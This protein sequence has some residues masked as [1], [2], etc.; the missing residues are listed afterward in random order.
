MTGRRQTLGDV[1]RLA[2]VSLTTASVALTG[3]P[4]VAAETRSR[5]ERAAER[6]G[7]VPDSAG[8][9]LRSR[10]TGALAVVV[11]HS[12]RHF[13]SHPVLVDLLEGVMSVANERDL[14][15]IV[16]TSSTE[17]DEETA[18]D[19]VLRGRRADGL[20]VF[21]AA[22][23]DIHAAQL[24]RA[25][26][27]VVL[28]GR[29]PLMP[30]VCSVGLDDV[31]GGYAA[32]RH[33]IEAHGALRIAH[34]SGPLRH[35]SAIDKRDGY[36]AAL[37]DAGLTINP[38][39]QIEGDYTERSGWKAAHELLEHLGTF[40]AVFCA[41]D[42]M[43]MGALQVLQEAGACGPG[44]VYLA[45]YDDH[46][47]SQFIRPALTTVAAD[48]VNVGREAAARLLRV[49]EGEHVKPLHAL[50][51]TRLTVRGSCGCEPAAG[52]APG[53]EGPVTADGQRSASS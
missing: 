19:R 22:A 35:Q 46:P 15:T 20:I 48:L 23:T 39:L 45:G 36:V 9:A 18:Y 3:N 14:V 13:F 41:N 26:H 7:Y 8:R 24:A 33:L 6:L 37:R 2:G 4:G 47:L 40:E 25:G 21:S 29:A 53:D 38:R 49:M 51:P 30:D 27:P 17:E 44:G 5:V 43:A 12:T 50:L 32:T 42:Q 28:V 11:P 34:I 10:R 16:S 52:A 31:G 1:A